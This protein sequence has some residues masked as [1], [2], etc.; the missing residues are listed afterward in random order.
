MFEFQYPAW[1]S[2]NKDK[3]SSE[4]YSRYEQQLGQMKAICTEFEAETE[5]DTE[6]VKKERFSRIMD[7]M[8]SMEKLGLPPKELTGDMVST[9]S[10]SLFLLALSI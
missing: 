1:L 5:T 7:L 8:Q 6:E 3:V 9:P 10:L 2:E 4:E